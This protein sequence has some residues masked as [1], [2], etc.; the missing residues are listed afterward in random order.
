M[1]NIRPWHQKRSLRKRR[2]VQTT[3]PDGSY[4][5]VVSNFMKQGNG[6]IRFIDPNGREYIIGHPLDIQNLIDAQ[7]K[8][9]MD[10]W[11]GYRIKSIKPLRNRA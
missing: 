7:P 10:V 5:L 1:M 11:I 2:K 8:L 6:F 3:V 4:A 9:V